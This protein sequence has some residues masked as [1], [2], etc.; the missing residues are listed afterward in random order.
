MTDDD[1]LI[2]DQSNVDEDELDRRIRELGLEESPSEQARAEGDKIDDEFESR[3]KALEDKAQAH[4]QVRNNQKREAERKQ[5]S[6]RE[7]ARGLGVGL[8]IAYTII[9]M[10]IV[11]LIIGWILDRGT[12][13]Q[14]YKGLGVVVGMVLGIAAGLAILAK[15]NR[16]P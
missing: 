15:S 10:P 12:E 3:L 13:S 4:R 2:D 5:T 11:G 14:T 8:S 7:S 1:K 9:G 16:Q 6:D